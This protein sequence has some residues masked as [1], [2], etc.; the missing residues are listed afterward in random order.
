MFEAVPEQGAIGEPAQRVVEGLVLQLLLET[1]AL[2]HV[3]QG[4]DDTFEGRFV[5]QVGRCHLDVTPRT[6]TMLDPPFCRGRCS[7]SRRY[8]CV[9][10]QGLLDVVGVEQSSEPPALEGAVSVPEDSV[11]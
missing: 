9:L 3:P 8:A 1:R 2:T 6:V 4:E 10:G 11:G 7:G 5:H